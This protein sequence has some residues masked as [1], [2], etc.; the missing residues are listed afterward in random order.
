MWLVR[1]GDAD[2]GSAAG[3]TC[4]GRRQA[5]RVASLLE[6]KDIAAVYS[7]DDSGARDTAALIAGRLGREVVTDRR[8][9]RQ[10]VGE[11]Y[12]ALLRRSIGVLDRIR[13]RR[14]VGDVVLVVHGDSI[15]MLRA[16]SSGTPVA[17]LPRG[18]VTTASVCR[19]VVAPPDGPAQVGTAP[20]TS[21]TWTP[22]PGSDPR[23]EASPKLNTP[24]SLPIRL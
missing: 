16:V 20:T 3:L 6:G 4:T 1:Q 15:R 14:H 8:L 17:D 10:A 23:L 5:L 19:V 9:R 2:R 24:P 22:S 12:Q 13:S 11:P 7:S 18:T 21:S